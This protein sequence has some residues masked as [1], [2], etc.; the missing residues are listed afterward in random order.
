MTDEKK[1]D[2]MEDPTHLVWKGS[3]KKAQDAMRE[4]AMEENGI[5]PVKGLP[6]GSAQ[7]PVCGK[8]YE[9]PKEP[10]TPTE[11]EMHMSGICSDACWDKAFGGDEVRDLDGFDGD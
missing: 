1:P 9:L 5:T 10:K 4:A 7:C 3:L 6:V 11:R 2:G 8:V